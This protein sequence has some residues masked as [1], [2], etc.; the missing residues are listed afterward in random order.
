MRQ[1]LKCDCG[2]ENN[3][4]GTLHQQNQFLSFFSNIDNFNFNKY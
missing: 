1:V 4:L 2:K 3:D